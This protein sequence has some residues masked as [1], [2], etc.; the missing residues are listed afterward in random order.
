MDPVCFSV[1][2]FL[3]YYMYI[4]PVLTDLTPDHIAKYK[5]TT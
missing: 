2:T 3:T 1:I 5:H 4:C